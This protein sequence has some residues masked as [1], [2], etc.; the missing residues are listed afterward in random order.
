M[1]KSLPDIIIHKARKIKL[2][3]L[4]PIGIQP[5]WQHFT[6]TIHKN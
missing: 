1:K 3:R 4:K 5:C 2:P 6:Y